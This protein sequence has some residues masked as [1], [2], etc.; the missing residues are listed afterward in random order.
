MQSPFGLQRRM[1]RQESTRSTADLA[2]QLDL[3][4]AQ[5]QAQADNDLM[6]A[7]ILPME[8]EL[9]LLRER[10]KVDPH[11]IRVLCNHFLVPEYW[12]GSS[13]RT[14]RSGSKLPYPQAK[15][16]SCR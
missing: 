11:H 12:L 1:R 8:Q 6:R 16:V 15:P 5:A 2:E 3:E 14:S 9:A 10:T 4:K 13:C 7:L